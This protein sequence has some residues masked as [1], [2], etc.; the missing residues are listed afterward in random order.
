V[1]QTAAPQQEAAGFGAGSAA[2]LGALTL[3]LLPGSKRRR[4]FLANLSLVLLTIA[5][6]IGMTGCASPKPITGGTPPGVY[7]VSVT[8]T[9][10]GGATALT[11][12]AVVT[13]TVKSLF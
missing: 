13:L 2:F 6:S 3:L 12:S 10:P 9:A 7:S 4:R 1:I 8:A 5:A 11:H